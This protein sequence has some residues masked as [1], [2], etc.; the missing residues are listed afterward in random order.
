MESAGLAQGTHGIAAP[1]PRGKAMDSGEP[2]DSN[3]RM[4]GPNAP[5]GRQ[6]HPECLGGA[7]ASMRNREVKVHSSQA[8]ICAAAPAVETPRL[9]LRG[10]CGADLPHCLS[11]WSDPNVTRF[12][13]GKP[14]SEQQTWARLLA[15]VGHWS[16]KGFGYWIIEEKETGGFVGEIGFADYK[17][18]IA[19]AMRGVP[20]LG[21]ALASRCHGRG[22]A[23]EAVGAVVA[24]ADAHIASRRTVCLVSEQNSASLRVLAKCGYGVFDHGLY[25]GQPVLFLARESPLGG[26]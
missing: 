8:P 3:A 17:R 25:N 13:G 22:Y 21:F 26:R 14:S 19:V 4:N 24:W 18:D 6:P 5:D 10:H 12:I 16:V 11:M 7:C 23:T 1:D 15:Y 2:M 9:R 20:E